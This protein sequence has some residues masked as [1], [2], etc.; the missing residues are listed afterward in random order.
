MSCRTYDNFLFHS[1][2]KE[3]P[4][5][6]TVLN[7]WT[8]LL[9]NII[10]DTISMYVSMIR[11]LLNSYL[12]QDQEKCTFKWAI[13]CI[14]SWSHCYDVIFQFASYWFLQQTSCTIQ[15]CLNVIYVWN[16]GLKRY[17]FIFYLFVNKP[18]LIFN[19]VNF[20]SGDLVHCEFAQWKLRILNIL[21]RVTSRRDT[22]LQYETMKTR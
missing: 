8:N 4:L 10:W 5:H 16:L 12:T 9:H 13:F 19:S 15:H 18:P 21:W 17:Y 1:N 20:V 14:F 7:D 3:W 11:F 22:V 6:S 2:F